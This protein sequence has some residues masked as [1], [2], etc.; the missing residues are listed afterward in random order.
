MLSEAVKHSYW[1]RPY[2]KWGLFTWEEFYD[3]K[4]PNKSKEARDSFL[5][6]LETEDK[7]GKPNEKENSINEIKIKHE[8][9][10]GT[11]LRIHYQT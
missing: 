1:N 9:S 3:D 7:N 2:K 6:D 11:S 8:I 5:C 4:Y 10:T